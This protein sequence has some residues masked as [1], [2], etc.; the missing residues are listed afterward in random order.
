M[1]YEK[2]GRHGRRLAPVVGV[3]LLTW[4]VAVA[5]HPAWVPGALGGVSS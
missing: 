4:G 3:V 1:Y 5:L 2:A